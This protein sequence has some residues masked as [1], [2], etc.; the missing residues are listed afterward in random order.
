MPLTDYMPTADERAFADRVLPFVRARARQGLEWEAAA[1]AGMRDHLALL[2]WMTSEEADAQMVRES[3]LRRTYNHHRAEAGLSLEVDEAADQAAE[4]ALLR[5]AVA[6]AQ[7]P[8]T[9]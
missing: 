5:K 3:I 2:Q 7:E 1:E 8:V 6:I 4:V 9:P